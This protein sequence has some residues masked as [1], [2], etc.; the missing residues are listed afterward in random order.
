MHQPCFQGS[1]KQVISPEHE[2]KISH[3]QNFKLPAIAIK[4]WRW[5]PMVGV[6]KCMPITSTGW[7]CY[8]SDLDLHSFSPLIYIKE[9][10][11]ALPKSENNKHIINPPCHSLE[12]CRPPKVNLKL[13]KNFGVVPCQLKYL[14]TIGKTSCL[15]NKTCLLNCSQSVTWVSVEPGRYEMG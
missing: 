12:M 11:K 3:L 15:P 1:Q 7:A 10:R 8:Q 14:N 2:Y 13:S 9:R 4:L 5:I 6:E